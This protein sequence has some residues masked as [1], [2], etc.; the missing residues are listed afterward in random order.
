M[1]GRP[2]RRGVPSVPGPLFPL[3]YSHISADLPLDQLV[4]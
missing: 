1:G 4:W 3:S 2:I